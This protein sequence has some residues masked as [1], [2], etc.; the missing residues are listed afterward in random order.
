MSFCF[1]DVTIGGVPCA[2]RIV[3]ELFD[4]IT[5][6]TCENFRKLCLGNDGKTLEG[7]GI[8]LS[9][10]GCGFHRI[11][12]K[13]MIQG[14]DFT[15]GDG[16]GGASIFGEKFEDENFEVKFGKPG[17][18]A[19]ANAGPNTNGS[20][21]F[22]T[23][24]ACHHLS[25]KHV[26]FGKVIRGMNTVRELEHCEKGQQ[27]R[28][29]RPC[30]IAN[31]GTLEAS[32]IPAVAV[33]VD[34]DQFPDYP[35]DLETT[36]SDKQMTD[37][38]ES[39][40]KIGNTYFGSGNFQ[41]AIA[42][43]AKTIRYCT[44]INKSSANAEVLDKKVA[45]CYSNTA[46]CYIK[47][48]KWPECRIAATEALAIEPRNVKALYRR[49]VALMQL[50]DYAAAVAD[51]TLVAQEDPGNSDAAAKLAEAK[52]LDK[53]QKGKLGAAMM[54]SFGGGQ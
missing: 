28:P 42:K 21:F 2:E 18:L 25:G 15:R 11:I 43:Y 6:K 51:L 53:Q 40:S 31:C 29:T 54:K 30:V 32:E 5:P 24:D 34:G 4:S 13:F 52:S 45:T 38:A 48:N 14:G 1:F 47:L 37:A 10:K 7:S 35:A 3:F 20:Q 12:E 41:A 23:T 36:L 22:I 8:P 27:D 39:I 44:A 50:R 49:G 46:M 19:M 17:L 16:T 9:Y 26:V 33:S